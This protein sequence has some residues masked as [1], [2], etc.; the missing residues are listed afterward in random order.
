MP[1][2]RNYL[3]AAFLLLPFLCPAAEAPQPPATS[4]AKTLTREALLAFDQAVQA[5]DFTS[6]HGFISDVWRAQITP[7]KLKTIFQ[8]FIDQQLDFSFVSSLD[9]VF[10]KPAAIDDD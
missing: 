5:K 2:M 9:P 6:F 3:A 4:E 1:L 10:T 7:A 8:A